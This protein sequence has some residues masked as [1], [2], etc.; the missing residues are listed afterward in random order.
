MI[1]FDSIFR[2]TYIIQS[3]SFDCA[4][5]PENIAQAFWKIF[6]VFQKR[7]VLFLDHCIQ[8]YFQNHT[9]NLVILF[10]FVQV[11][12]KTLRRR[13][14]KYFLFSKQK[15]FYFST[16]AFDSIFRITYIVYCQSFDLCKLARKHYVGVLKNIFCFSKKKSFVC[17]PLQ[18]ILFLESHIIQSYSFDLCK[19][20]HIWIR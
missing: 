8:F 16:I 12:S 18:S 14:E 2:I 9:H 4:S 17:R 5:W 19:S 20:V 11:G 7:K 1:A 6:F 13:F 10:C 3:Y 15:K